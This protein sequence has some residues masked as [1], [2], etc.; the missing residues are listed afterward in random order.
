MNVYTR[1]NDIPIEDLD[2]IP[3]SALY[4]LSSKSVDDEAITETID[5]A[6]A[7][8]GITIAQAKEIKQKYSSSQ[9]DTSSTNTQQLSSENSTT[10]KR[11]NSDDRVV[12]PDTHEI[13]SAESDNGLTK[14]ISKLSSD[15]AISQPS[16][17]KPRLPKLKQQIIKV[18]P[19]QRLWKIDDH[20]IYNGEP[21]SEGFLKQLPSQSSICLNFSSD[22]HFR[23]DY[24]NY[25]SWLSL[26]FKH[27]DLDSN[28]FLKIIDQIVASS[29]EESDSVIVLYIPNEDI[30]NV[31]HDLYCKA[32]IVD[33]DPEKCLKLANQRIN[34]LD[35]V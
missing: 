31:I 5:L 27:S 7:E 11:D 26:Y 6:K 14:P 3:V 35:R 12:I 32:Y 4:E 24:Q 23:F 10:Q 2:L 20:I 29:T 9:N 15:S 18:L 1:F 17:T 19:Q 33:P 21:N 30:L 25:H 28:D 16:E 34:N 13:T 22:P 8:G